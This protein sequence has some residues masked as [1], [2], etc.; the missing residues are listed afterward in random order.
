MIDQE[1]QNAVLTLYKQGVPHKTISR[2]LHIDT[3]TVRVIVSRGAAREPN[4]ANRKKIDDALLSQL[5]GDCKGYVQR[6]HEI[7]AEKHGVSIGYSTLARMV[8]NSG[9]GKVVDDRSSRVPD[10]PGEEMQHDTSDYKITIGSS[11][12]KLICSGLYLRYSKM[13]YIRFYRRFNRF[14]M[15]C[16]FDEALR[17]WGYCARTCII[18]NTHLAIL[19]GSGSSARMAPEMENFA[20]NYGFVWKAHAIG[21][22]NRKAGTERN[23]HTVETNFIPGRTFSSLEDCNMQAIEWA[24]I[25]YA[26]RPQTKTKLIPVE[27][28]E[29]E[30]GMLTQLP[31]YISSPYLPHERC[32][33]T[34]GYCSF[35]GNFYWVPKTPHLT[36]VTILQYAAHLRIMNG[37]DEIIQYPIA[38]DGVKNVLVAPQGHSDIVRYVPKNRKMGY[39]KEEM[40]LCELGNDA[41]AYIKN[42]MSA[43]S[44]VVHRGAFIRGLHTLQRR[45]GQSIFLK[46]LKRAAQYQVFDLAAIERI[47]RQIIRIDCNEIVIEPDIT[48]DYRSR[49]AFRDGQF[50]EEN[51]G[52][53]E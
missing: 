34:Y 18:D 46:A 31:D 6:M 26:Q 42:A 23:F 4:P 32:L 12:Q 2:Q 25:H 24:T 7:L 40:R 50:S 10:M 48:E 45:F 37:T 19:L 22:A 36:S 28:F 13:R 30:K 3:K 44:G 11:V 38:A 5:Y 20:K 49:D 39:E 27:L 15:K 51:E 17:H 1:R 53:Y 21:H 52:D 43:S 47:I 16:F 33:D 14:T 29:T 41:T 35:D 9:L 8:R